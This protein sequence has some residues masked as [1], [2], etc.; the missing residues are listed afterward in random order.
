MKNSEIIPINLGLG[1]EE[2][3]L[4]FRHPDGSDKLTITFRTRY[5]AE[6]ARSALASGRLDG[7][8]QP[9]PRD[10]A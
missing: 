7:S 9:N 8:F 2:F 10:T 5:D 6:K 4:V 1:Q 3:L